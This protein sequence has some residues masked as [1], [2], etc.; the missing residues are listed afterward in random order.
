MVIA[1]DLVQLPC[2]TASIAQLQAKLDSAN[3]KSGANQEAKLEREENVSI[4]GSNARLMIMQKLSRKTDV[5]T[6]VLKFIFKCGF[7]L[8]LSRE[9]L[10]NHVR[11]FVCP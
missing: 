2:P 4:S 5:S 9:S 8:W 11:I 7:F 3:E 6:L 1:Y 10:Q